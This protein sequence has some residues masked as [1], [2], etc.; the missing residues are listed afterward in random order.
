M[1]SIL[2]LCAFLFFGAQNASA[3]EESPTSSSADKATRPDADSCLCEKKDAW[4]G[5]SINAFFYQQD[6]FKSSSPIFPIERFYQVGFYQIRSKKGGELDT[7]LL[8][9]GSTNEGGFSFLFESSYGFDFF[10]SQSFAFGPVGGFAL[11]GVTGARLPFTQRF[12]IGLLS[13]ISIANEVRFFGDAGMSW[14]FL[15]DRARRVDSRN[16]SFV[17]ETSAKIGFSFYSAYA[18]LGYREVLASR[19]LQFQVGLSLLDD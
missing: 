8:T 9:L 19:D 1:K 15:T 16:I 11:D 18:S 12:V 13:Y 17:D 2:L 6:N 7:T 3:Q 14:H 10:S 5:P 4:D